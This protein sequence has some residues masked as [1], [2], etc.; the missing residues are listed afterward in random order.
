MRD[1]KIEVIGAPCEYGIEPPRSISHGVNYHIK[2][3]SHNIKVRSVVFKLVMAHLQAL[4]VKS[5]F[6]HHCL[7]SKLDFF[8][9]STFFLNITVH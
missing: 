2:D 4:Y 6:H 8:D 7:S 1:L 3:I 5:I 9:V